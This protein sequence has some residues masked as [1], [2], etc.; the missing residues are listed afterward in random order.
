MNICEGPR[1]ITLEGR[2]SVER[3]VVEEGELDGVEG[4]RQR[5]YVQ[6]QQQLLRHT[7]SIYMYLDW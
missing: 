4:R 5:R 3:R 7:I 2:K 1:Q 6:Q